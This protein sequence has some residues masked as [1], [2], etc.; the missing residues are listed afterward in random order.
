MEIVG[1]SRGQVVLD[2][3]MQQVFPY[4][5]DQKKILS[6]NPF[7]KDVVETELDNVNRWDFEIT[8]PRS[9]PIR[10]I[11]FVEQLEEHYPAPTHDVVTDKI[12]W[13]D[14]PVDIEGN[15]PDDHT[16]LGKA[17]GEM[18]LKRLKSGSTF[19]DVTMRVIV[20][21]DVPV[22]LRAFPEPIIKVMA[23][24]AMSFGMQQVSRKMLENIRKDFQ[25]ALVSA[26]N[27]GSA[28][29]N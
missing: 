29:M 21:F 17:A 10:I 9:H 2:A 27:T 26:S 24:T 7:C 3:D 20:D 12:F 4:F 5:A 16:F 28:T 11:F 19:I 25:C 22:L 18:Q 14:Y 1:T 8:D 6:F 13:L 15:M 23:E